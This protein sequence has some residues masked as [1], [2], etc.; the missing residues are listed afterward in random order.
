VT[1]LAASCA[2]VNRERLTKEVLTADPA[3]TE[4]L[5]KHRE[6]TSRLETFERQ[7]RF[8]REQVEREIKQQRQNLG[9]LSASLREK[10]RETRQLMAPDRAR[11]EHA[12]AMASGEL[13]AK[14]VQR[15]AVGRSIAQLKKLSRG[16]DSAFSAQEQAQ[17]AAQLQELGADAA[18]LDQELQALR[19]HVQLLKLKLLLIRV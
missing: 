13:H 18:R 4:V 11:L 19:R 9:A 3:F 17:H 2:P 16:N 12:L 1:L 6:V 7:L 14:R 15:A 5:A 8:K 10:V